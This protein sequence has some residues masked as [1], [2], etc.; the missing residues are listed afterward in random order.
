MKINA[1]VTKYYGGILKCVVHADPKEVKRRRDRERY[2]QN[3]E[4]ISKRRKQL[5][6]LKKQSI[7]HVSDQNNFSD[8]QSITQPVVTQRQTK[9]HV[10]YILIHT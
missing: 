9:N 5:R 6:E 3:K 7:C 1:T 4:E 8:T 10:L 2:A